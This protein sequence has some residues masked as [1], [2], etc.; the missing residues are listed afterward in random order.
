MENLL[1]ESLESSIKFEEYPSKLIKIVLQVVCNEGN[2]KK[3]ISTYALIIF[4]S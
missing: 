4:F 3:D 2:V 1:S